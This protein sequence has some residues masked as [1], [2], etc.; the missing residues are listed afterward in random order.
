MYLASGANVRL[1]LTCLYGQRASNQEVS[2]AKEIAAH[3]NI[4]HQTLDLS[5]MGKFP[6]ALTCAQNAMP[7]P[8]REELDDAQFTQASAKAVWVPNRNG[9]FLEAASGFA[10]TLGASHVI[11]GFNREEA[12]TFPDNSSSYLNAINKALAFSTQGRVQIVSPTVMMDK[13]EIVAWARSN[14]FPLHLVWS[15]Y[16]AREKMCGRCESCQRLKR[17]I[18]DPLYIGSRFETGL[19]DLENRI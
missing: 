2:H 10:E 16:E 13:S 7:S 17:A 11:V 3:F 15:C 8:S 19:A 4:P 12:A 9:I 5:W 14:H 6:S 18:D 1:A